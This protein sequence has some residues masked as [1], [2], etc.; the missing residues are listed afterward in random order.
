VFNAYVVFILIIPSKKEKS[1]AVN[2]LKVYRN[3]NKN[4]CLCNHLKNRRLEEV[5]YSPSFEF[6]GVYSKSPL[7]GF[8]ADFVTPCN[9]SHLGIFPEWLFCGT[10]FANK[11]C[12]G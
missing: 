9:I 12:A 5:V 3:V 2:F 4:I 10:G 11:D 6:T 7:Q 1:S 8:G